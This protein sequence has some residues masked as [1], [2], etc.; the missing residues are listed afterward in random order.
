MGL[1]SFFDRTKEGPG[2]RADEPKKPPFMMFF[3]I[4]GRKIWEMIRLNLMHAIA[5]IPALVAAYLISSLFFELLAERMGISMENIEDVIRTLQEQP[6]NIA[7][8]LSGSVIIINQLIITGAVLMV[9]LGL[10]GIGPLQAGFS[11]IL[12]NISGEQHAFLWHDYWKTAKKNLGQSLAVMGINLVAVLFI[13][14][15]F[16]SWYMVMAQQWADNI[17]FRFSPAVMLLLLMLFSMM[18]IYIYQMMVTFKFSIRQLYKNS[19]LLAMAKFLPNLGILAAVVFVV[20]SFFLFNALWGTLGYLVIVPALCSY[21]MNFY[22]RIVLRKYLILT[23][24]QR[25]EERQAELKARQAEKEKKSR[26]RKK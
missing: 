24:E 9:C 7:N 18:Q 12:R 15:W 17:I 10:I 19:F 4:F 25:E 6:E 2:V 13:A 8:M 16:R 26:A 5:S 23:P 22:A 20:S 1:F 3:I 11:Y 21:I 14:F